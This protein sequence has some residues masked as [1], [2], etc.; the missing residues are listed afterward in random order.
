MNLP[1]FKYHP[2]PI[3]TGSVAA[4]DILC[5]SCGQVRGFIYKGPV[6]T[7]EELDHLICPWCIADGTAHEKFDA[8]FIDAA[9]VGGYGEWEEVSDEAIEEIAYRTPGFNGWQQE[10]WF[11]HCG[12]AAEFLGPA[13]KKEIESFGLE[14]VSIIKRESGYD[15]EAWNEYFQSLDKDFGPTAYIFRC[16]HCGAFGG[17]SDCH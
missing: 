1:T 17:Y 10:R 6:Y 11:T 2:D 15:G 16:R 9:G 12:D 5:E 14:A 4:S 13:G 8:T 7:I 3:A